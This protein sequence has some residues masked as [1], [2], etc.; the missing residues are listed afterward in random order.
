MV[1]L[2]VERLVLGDNRITLFGSP[3]TVIESVEE[4][5]E[6]EI[7]KH[8]IILLETAGKNTLRPKFVGH[9]VVRNLKEDWE[10]LDEEVNT[11]RLARIMENN[12][13][14]LDL[15]KKEINEKK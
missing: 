11:E 13:F 14:L 7:K 9:K 1:N 8:N 15:E 2:M 6:K 3:H 4:E 10:A 5:L 12:P